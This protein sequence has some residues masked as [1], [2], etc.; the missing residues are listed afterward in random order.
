MTF[1]MYRFSLFLSLFIFLFLA[2]S[3]K[4]ENPGPDNPVPT[5]PAQYETPFTEIPAT[6]DVVMY[7]I[8]ERAFSVSGDFAGILPRLDS[9][10]ALGV[11]VIWLMPIHPIGAINS[12]NSPYCIK[13]FTEVNP[14]FGNRLEFLR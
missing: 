11:N 9:I 13:N 3:C 14:E 6:S 12:V 4:K 5:D 2:L 1:R 7:E 8:N 10:K